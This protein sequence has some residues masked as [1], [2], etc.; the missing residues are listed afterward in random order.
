MKQIRTELATKRLHSAMN[1]IVVGKDI[2]HNRK[3]GVVS[4]DW[5]PI[6]KVEAKP[7]DDFSITWNAPV[8]HDLGINKQLILDRFNADGP[9]SSGIGWG[10]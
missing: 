5:K 7:N 2:H 10:E 9:T 8:V 4:I 3:S 1:D 6:A